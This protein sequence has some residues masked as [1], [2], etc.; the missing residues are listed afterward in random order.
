MILKKYYI[1]IFFISSISCYAQINLNHNVIG[2]V[3]GSNIIGNWNV[4]Y[5]VGEAIVASILDTFDLTQ[6]FHQPED[7]DTLVID[8]LI[9]I[10]VNNSKCIGANNGSITGILNFANIFDT[11][12][13][14]IDYHPGIG[15][16]I[17]IIDTLFYPPFQNDTI[18]T[19]NILLPGSYIVYIDLNNGSSPTSD[20]IILS[21]TQI[22]CN[23]LCDKILKFYNGFT[24]N[25]D[26]K[27]DKWEIDGIE[28]FPK[29]E[30]YIFNRWGGIVWDTKDK[31]GYN[32]SNVVWDGKS[33]AGNELPD[34]TYFYI[35]EVKDEV[36]KGWIELTH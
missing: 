8:S 16:P 22:R 27:N 3:G 23:E 19:E 12:N 14:T 24:P 32:N 20:T 5:T 17:N 4:D 29:N 6:G 21:E 30:V 7:T 25:N 31:D 36:C 18:T 33:N 1:Y 35:V 13:V 9:T 15:N 26:N 34:A 10:I 2:S 11:V 28:D